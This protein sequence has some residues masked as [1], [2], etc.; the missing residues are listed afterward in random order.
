MRPAAEQMTNRRESSSTGPNRP[1]RSRGFVFVE[2]VLALLVLVLAIW[3]ATELLARG[4]QR[5]R[6]DQFVTDLRQFSAAI[7]HYARQPRSTL[8]AGSQPSALPPALAAVLK[9]TNWA[10]GSPFGGTYEWIPSPAP[11]PT[12]AP[13]AAAR[14]AITADTVA[15]PATVSPR[16]DAPVKQPPAAV[17]ARLGQIALTAFAPAFPLAVARADLLYIDRQI[18]DGNLATGRFRTGFNGW[19]IWEVTGK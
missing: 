8:G 10:A 17:R 14:P 12:P 19:P 16:N 1:A 2:A 5:R 3:L 13:A 4:R 11:P 15:I 9:E 7:Q 18:D 6:C